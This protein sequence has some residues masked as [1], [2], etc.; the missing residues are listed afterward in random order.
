MMDW[1]AVGTIL[2]TG[3][4]TL[5][6]VWLK[7]RFDYRAERERREDELAVAKEAQLRA[8]ARS[9]AEEEARAARARLAEGQQILSGFATILEDMRHYEDTSTPDEMEEA[10]SQNFDH[11]ARLLVERV[12]DSSV[13]EHMYV[14]LDALDLFESWT[15]KNDLQHLAGWQARTLA[16]YLVELSGVYAREE[17]ALGRGLE[18]NLQLVRERAERALR[19]SEDG[20]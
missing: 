5:G 18:A 3:G 4:V 11:K 12:T 16:R 9:V 6:S 2:A 7:G 8:D 20:F 14:V 19:E 1:T 15:E 10:W 13:R 17:S